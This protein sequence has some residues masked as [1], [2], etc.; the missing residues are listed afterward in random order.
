MR[1]LMCSNCTNYIYMYSKNRK[2]KL[3]ILGAVQ[4]VYTC[5]MGTIGSYE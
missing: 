5:A 2:L 1:N 3:K 4:C